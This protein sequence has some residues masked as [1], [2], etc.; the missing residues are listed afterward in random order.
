MS[1]DELVLLMFSVESA[2]SFSSASLGWCLFDCRWALLRVA[3][4]SCGFFHSAS[5]GYASF[6][7]GTRS[8]V[9][10]NDMCPF[11][12]AVNVSGDGFCFKLVLVTPIVVASDRVSLRFESCSTELCDVTSL[13][14]SLKDELTIDA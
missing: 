12:R 11:V 8:M 14:A 1:E 13:T 7:D 4:F 5:L 9:S 2:S 6:R 3:S 10:A